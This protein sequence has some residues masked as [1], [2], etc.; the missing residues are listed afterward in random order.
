MKQ[1]LTID[2][3]EKKTKINFMITN[4]TFLYYYFS[5]KLYSRPFQL[6]FIAIVTFQFWARLTGGSMLLPNDLNSPIYS[7][8]YCWI[9]NTTAFDIAKIDLLK[10]VEK[11]VPLVLSRLWA[12]APAAIRLL[13]FPPHLF[14]TEGKKNKLSESGSRSRSRSQ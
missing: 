1:S 14:Q 7:S 5:R 13:H 4:F 11:Q 2:E 9:R 12:G 10:Q 8:K 3:C 6:G